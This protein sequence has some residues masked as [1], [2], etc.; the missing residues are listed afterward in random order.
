MNMKTCKQLCRNVE[1]ACVRVGGA[2]CA[3]VALTFVEQLLLPFAV[4][5]PLRPVRITTCLA[6]LFFQLGIV[7]E[8]GRLA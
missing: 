1:R 3:H 5:I 6:E 8:G 4:L 7:G 2:P